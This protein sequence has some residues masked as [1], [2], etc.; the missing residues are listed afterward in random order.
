MKV[1]TWN[2]K[3]ASISRPGVWEQLEQEDADIVFV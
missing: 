1:L 2:V 3:R